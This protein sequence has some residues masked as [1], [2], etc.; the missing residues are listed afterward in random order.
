MPDATLY[1]AYDV[2]GPYLPLWRKFAYCGYC[3]CGTIAS[4]N[5]H[6]GWSRVRSNHTPIAKMEAKPTLSDINVTEN[7]DWYDK[8][9][10]AVQAVLRKIGDTELARARRVSK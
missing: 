2:L 4:Q 9:P 1:E 7:I 8:S 5:N 10:L 6:G 3:M